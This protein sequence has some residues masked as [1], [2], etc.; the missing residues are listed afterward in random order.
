MFTVYFLCIL[1]KKVEFC[2][3]RF[4][5]AAIVDGE[6]FPMGSGSSKKNAKKAAAAQALKIMYDRGRKNLE[7]V[8]EVAVSR[9]RI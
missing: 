3:F 4:H 5:T 7:A 1:V 6:T 9:L 2:V 8:N